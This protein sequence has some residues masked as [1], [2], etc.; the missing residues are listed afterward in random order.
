VVWAHEQGC[1]ALGERLHAVKVRFA[2]EGINIEEPFLNA[3]ALDEYDFYANHPPHSRGVGT[4]ARPETDPDVDLVPATAFLDTAAAI[5]HH[6]VSEAI[7]HEGLCNW[8]GPVTEG[9]SRR[10]N[11]GRACSALAGDLYSG[12]AGV[13]FFLADLYAR[14]GDEECLQTALGAIRHALS[15]VEDFPASTRLGLYTGWPGLALAA[16]RIGTLTGRDDLLAQSRDVMERC[17]GEEHPDHP[18]DLL[19]GSAGALVASLALWRFSGKAALL[20]YAF[21][22][23]EELLREAEET[24]I[25]LSWRSQGIEASSNLTG[26]SHGTAGIAYALMELDKATGHE[27]FYR[28]AER[29]LEYERHL[30][31]P[32]KANWPDF[33]S[34]Q[35]T[36]RGKRGKPG[37]QHRT[38]A[39]YWCHGA[40]GIALSRLRAYSQFGQNLMREEAVTALQTTQTM[41]EEALGLGMGQENYSLCHGLAGNA[42]VLVY[43][44]EVLGA[45][46]AQSSKALA[47]AH[48]VGL[49]GIRWYGTGGPVAWPCGAGGGQSPALMLGLAGIGHFYLRLRSPAVP[50]ILLVL[51][52]EWQRS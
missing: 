17:M 15:R 26:F 4:E 22:L 43:G 18:L 24:K 14:T 25:G 3:N 39:T 2:Q 35:D 28:A 5:G 1:V 34:P 7:W 29:A 52:E 11:P 42:G 30:F 19:S 10:G 50:S 32:Q 8:L 21:Q 41:V 38:F 16:A 51:P 36:P 20:D 40:P 23:G 27:L 12:S 13:A 47:T 9:V 31:D 48:Q 45:D 46:W 33:R 44:C 6:L 49:V 37:K